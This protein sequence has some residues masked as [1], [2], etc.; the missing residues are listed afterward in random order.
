MPTKSSMEL[1]CE[2]MGLRTIA[3]V[4]SVLNNSKA[5]LIC[6]PSLLRS[7]S[8]VPALDQAP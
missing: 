6:F 5:A 7:K 4:M 3:A 1:N 8:P 2:P